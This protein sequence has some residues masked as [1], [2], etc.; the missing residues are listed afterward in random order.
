MIPCFLSLLRHYTPA[1]YNPLLAFIIPV[2]GVLG[3]LGGGWLCD[4]LA[5]SHP[6][7]GRRWLLAVSTAGAGPLIAASL[8]A[9]DHR[10]S[11]A[12]LFPGFMLSVGPVPCNRGRPTLERS[13]RP[14]RL[15]KFDCEKDITVLLT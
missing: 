14:R 10:A 3:G 6:R 4:R 12:F 5:V 7:S 11:M 15:S 9:P 2:S 8:L 13:Q 1:V